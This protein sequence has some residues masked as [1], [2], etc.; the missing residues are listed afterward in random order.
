MG[1]RFEV[2]TYG[3]NNTFFVL[4]P[5]KSDGTVYSKGENCPFFVVRMPHLRLKTVNYFH[6]LLHLRCWTGSYNAPLK[7]MTGKAG[8][9]YQK[10]LAQRL[11]SILIN[12]RI[13]SEYR[14]IRTRKISVFGH[15]SRS[16]NIKDYDAENKCKYSHSNKNLRTKF[17]LTYLDYGTAQTY[18]WL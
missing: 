17:E 16:D 2:R 18:Q 3:L 7:L 1:K 13:H 4:C 12:L 6:K 8:N 9:T 15:F 14:K 11:S 10:Q 5:T